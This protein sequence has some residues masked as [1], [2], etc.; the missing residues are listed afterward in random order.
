[1]DGSVLPGLLPSPRQPGISVLV[2]LGHGQLG[3]RQAAQDAIVERARWRH[4]CGTLPEV[5]VR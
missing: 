4:V 5:W 2:G 3:R 1:M